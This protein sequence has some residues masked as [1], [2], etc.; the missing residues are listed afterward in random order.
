M[1][2]KKII[3]KVFLVITTIIL[4]WTFDFYGA[5]RLFYGDINDYYAWAERANGSNSEYQKDTSICNNNVY[6]DK[7]FQE[8]NYHIAR[9]D[10]LLEKIKE[11][12]N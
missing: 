3:L 4:S 6:K 5:D 11:R 8:I 12:S 2:Q 1:N 7:L 10:C 9:K